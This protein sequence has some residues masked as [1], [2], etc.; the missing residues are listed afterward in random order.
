MTRSAR[1]LR[2]SSQGIYT[3]SHLCISGSLRTEVLNSSRRSSSLCRPDTGSS[4]D[5]APLRYCRVTQ[6]CRAK[7]LLYMLE[8][9][10]KNLALIFDDECI[11]MKQAT[12]AVS[13]VVRSSPFLYTVRTV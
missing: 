1:P 6:G 9:M 3:V 11:G 10:W 12:M 2:A 4:T 7:A 8:A 13:V 5:K